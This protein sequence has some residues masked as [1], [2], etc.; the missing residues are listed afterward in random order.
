M[1]A[2]KQIIQQARRRLNRFLH[3]PP[4]IPQGQVVQAENIAAIV[5]GVDYSLPVLFPEWMHKLPGDVKQ[6]YLAESTAQTYRFQ[7]DTPQR[8]GNDAPVQMPT[9][10]PLK[11]WDWQTR[12]MILSNCHAAYHRNP[13]ANRG[14]KYFARF[15][16]GEGFNLTCKNKDVEKLLQDFIDHPDNEIRKYE[17]MAPID[18]LVDGEIIIRWFGGDTPETFPPAAVPQRPWELEYIKTEK[19]FFKR[20]LVYHFERQLTEGDAPL[21]M[22]GTEPDDVPA[23]DIQFV[24]I[25]QHGYELRGRPELYGALPW[26]RAYK[27]WLENRARQ[28]HWRG[29]LL[30]WVKVVSNVPNA[31]ATVAA[32]WAKPPT[33][34][35]VAV[36]TANEEVTALTNPTGAGEASEDGRQIKM[37]SAVGM[38]V[39]EFMLSDGYN[40]NLATASAQQMPALIT[41]EDMQDVLV[42]QLWYPMFK[43]VVQIAVDA[44]LLPE[45]VE[46]QD[47][48]GDPVRED[49]EE[50]PLPMMQVLPQ[51]S[52]SGNGAMP[53]PKQGKKKTL[54]AVDAFDVA[55]SPVIQKDPFTLSQALQIQANRG[56]VS[57][58]TASTELGHDYAIEQKR[59]KRQQVKDQRE[60]AMG[61]KAPPPGA[62]PPGMAGADEDAVSADA[63]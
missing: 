18:L 31:V 53:E 23:Q 44:G 4:A 45:E 12:R 60:I 40:A 6:R 27:E 48:D 52:M 8:T 33:P 20:A 1:A 41:Y 21:G 37:M 24:A 47:A 56:W 50:E 29:A 17:R 55:Y 14:L 58:E 9:E 30:W 51:P 57:D 63:A 34:G 26:L 7:F 3:P 32:R 49:V 36:T 13:L 42:E 16:V 25:N 43:R 61:L 54:K 62:V 28:N 15:T 39:P 22:S 59:I 10:D 5:D 19:G 38:G 46:E 35:S 11:E 2:I